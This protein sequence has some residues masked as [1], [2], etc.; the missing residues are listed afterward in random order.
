MV[1]GAAGAQVAPDAGASAGGGGG[2]SSK[3]L[4]T[5]GFSVGDPDLLYTEYQ[6]Q[7]NMPR[8]P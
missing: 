3:N 7:A 1:A 5:I 6:A 4:F 2:E 8:R